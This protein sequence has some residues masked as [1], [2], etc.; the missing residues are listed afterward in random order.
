VQKYWEIGAL[1]FDPPWAQSP[2]QS[3]AKATAVE[4]DPAVE[5]IDLDIDVHLKH[6]PCSRSTMSGCCQSQWH[7]L[8]PANPEKNSPSCGGRKLRIGIEP[9]PCT[10]SVYLFDSTFIILA[11]RGPD[12]RRSGPHPEVE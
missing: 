6:H 5:V 8:T 9:G 12:R 10:I 11:R 4:L 1:Q 3:E 7:T 2:L